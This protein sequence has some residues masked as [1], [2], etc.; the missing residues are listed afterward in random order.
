MSECEQ[1]FGEIL[2][3]SLNEGEIVLTDSSG[4][5]F[6]LG[7][8]TSGFLCF[9]NCEGVETQV[10]LTVPGANPDRGI[11]AYS[12]SSAE[13][14]NADEKWRSADLVLNDGANDKV[15]PLLNSFKIIER[16]CPPIAP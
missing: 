2:V 7:S 15:I 12:I 4:K 3:G 10:T 16:A 8:Y 14:A 11:I 5:P 13:S 1:L 6:P 9:R